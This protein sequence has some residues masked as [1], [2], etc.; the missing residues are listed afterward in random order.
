MSR[1]PGIHAC[2][3]VTGFGL[4]GHLRELASASGVDVALD[5]DRV[6][7]LEGVR[8]LA[9]ADLVPGGSLENLAHV[10]P[11]VTWAEGQS[12]VD[13]RILADAQSSG[14][15]LIAVAAEHAGDLDAR[16]GARGV[17]G[18]RIGEATGSGRGR[19]TCRRG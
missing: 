9:S 2:T 13:K 3:D 10:S 15:L 8:A 16:F 4:L 6:P 19:I 18:A 5:A 11:H 14:G 12:E 17:S 7:V 1:A